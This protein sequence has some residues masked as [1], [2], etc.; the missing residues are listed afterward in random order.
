VLVL[1]D[2]RIAAEYAWA[3][4][5]E[6]PAVRARVLNDLGVSVDEAA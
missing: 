6:H 2:G 4:D 3:S 1:A 5:S